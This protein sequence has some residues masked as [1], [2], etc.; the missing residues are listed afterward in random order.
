M[1][2]VPGESVAYLRSGVA[3]DAEAGEEARLDG[4]ERLL[5]SLLARFATD[6]EPGW[7][8]GFAVLGG[9]GGADVAGIGIGFGSLFFEDE[10]LLSCG[11]GPG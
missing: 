8:R 4:R 5:G 9:G 6:D 3:G 2:G 7:G 1:G 11:R 10:F